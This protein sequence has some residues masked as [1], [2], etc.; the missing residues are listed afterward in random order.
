M[1]VEFKSEKEKKKENNLKYGWLNQWK[2]V[3]FYRER[4]YRF[5]FWTERDFI[6]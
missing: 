3:G 5:G 6:V 1:Y 2:K 4:A